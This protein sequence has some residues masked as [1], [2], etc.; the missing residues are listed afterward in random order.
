MLIQPFV[1]NAIEHGFKGIEQQGLIE[2]RLTKSKATPDTY[3]NCCI[4]DNGVGYAINETKTKKSASVELISS[5]IK[6][7]T[8][9]AISI[10]YRDK[11]K[12]TGTVI[13]F[14]IPTK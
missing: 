5:F 10:S 9:T 12:S 8:G 11:E 4:V 2:I 6:K 13:Q 3:I 14:K 1:E 7:A